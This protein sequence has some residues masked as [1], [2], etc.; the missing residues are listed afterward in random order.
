MILKK[1]DLCSGEINNKIVL[2]KHD[3]KDALGFDV[4]A[5]IFYL[6][7]RYEEYL[8]KPTDKFGNYDFKNSILYKLNCLHIPVVEQWINMLERSAYEKF[9]FV[10]IKKAPGK[11]C[12]KF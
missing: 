11:I 10:A 2:F 1:L 12:F 6:L 4:F 5:A 7:S 9:S 8:Q 3:K